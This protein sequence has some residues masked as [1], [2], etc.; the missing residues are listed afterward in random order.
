MIR[1]PPRSTLFPSTTLFR[2]LKQGQYSPYPVERQVASLWLGTTGKLDRVPVGDVRRFESEFLDFI[3][4]GD[5]GVYDEIRTSRAL[6]DD[7][8]RSLERAVDKIGR[9]SCR[10]RV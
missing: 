8:V 10:E 4:R 2:S 7:A 6:G 3:G 9:A 1:R 5:V